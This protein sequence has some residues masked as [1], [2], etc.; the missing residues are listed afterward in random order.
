MGS[1]MAA[2]D[3]LF[4]AANDAAKV[5][6]DSPEKERLQ[7]AVNLVCDAQILPDFVKIREKV[8]ADMADRL[9]G[10]TGNPWQ[11]VCPIRY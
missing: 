4:D 1:L 11:G 2:Y 9:K 6:P 7:W 8:D 10:V 5:M 3:R